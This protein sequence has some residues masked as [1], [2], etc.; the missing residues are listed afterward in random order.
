MKFSNLKREIAAYFVVMEMRI[1]LQNNK[2][3]SVENNHVT[4]TGENWNLN[5][6]GRYS[7]K[8]FKF[9]NMK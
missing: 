6:L 7:F 9:L 4:G 5:S 1:A 3:K 2:T 8:F